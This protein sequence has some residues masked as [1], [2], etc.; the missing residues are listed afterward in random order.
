MTH[1]TLNVFDFFLRSCELVS[2][3]LQ[4]GSIVRKYHSPFAETINKHQKDISKL[5]NDA[6]YNIRQN[7]LKTEYFHFDNFLKNNKN[8]TCNR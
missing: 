1:S 5:Y 7:H 3:I 8:C 6:N 2:R 4:S